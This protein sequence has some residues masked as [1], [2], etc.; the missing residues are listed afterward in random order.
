M[1]ESKKCCFFLFLPGENLPK[2]KG[3]DFKQIN[4]F[5][6]NYYSSYLHLNI[7]VS[8]KNIRQKGRFLFS[9]V[10]LFC[11]FGW[12]R[13]F[14]TILLCWYVTVSQRFLCPCLCSVCYARVCTAF[15]LPVFVCI[16]RLVYNRLFFF[17]L[18]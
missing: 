18:P 5:L 14:D 16:V 13:S 12:S 15:V 11:F 9:S 3:T 2:L 1:S 8:H 10:L 6:Y 7:S 17:N 4:Y